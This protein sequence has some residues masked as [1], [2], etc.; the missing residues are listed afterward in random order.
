MLEF[1]Q[2]LL[3]YL[4]VLPSQQLHGGTLQPNV[5]ITSNAVLS[6]RTS[7]QLVGLNAQPDSPKVVSHG[8][9]PRGKIC[10]CDIMCIY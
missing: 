9:V 7:N 6:P 4:Q 10:I 3:C 5:P 1:A 2:L 8:H